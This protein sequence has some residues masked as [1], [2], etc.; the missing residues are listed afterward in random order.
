MRGQ[1]K[2][3]WWVWESLWQ[4]RLPRVWGRGP[5]RCLVASVPRAV[6]GTVHACRLG[7]GRGWGPW[8][9]GGLGRAEVEENRFL[10][11]SRCLGGQ[12]PEVEGDS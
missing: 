3:T 2:G 4:E 7:G 11:K 1:A 6:L 8:E 10:S 12:V 9:G 5:S